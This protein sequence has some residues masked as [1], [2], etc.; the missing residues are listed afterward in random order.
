M[1]AFLRQLGLNRGMTMLSA[2]LFATAAAASS[3]SAV[4]WTVNDYPGTELCAA[5][6]YVKGKTAWELRMSP[7]GAV[8]IVLP[9]KNPKGFGPDDRFAVAFFKGADQRDRIARYFAEGFVGENSVGYLLMT[10]TTAQADKSNTD[11]FL[12]DFSQT[13]R[14]TISFEGEQFL[15]ITI[16]RSRQAVVGQMSACLSAVAEGRDF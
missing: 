2:I 3:D 16:P 8:S 4:G 10:Y 5:R 6:R 13:G 1:I 9:A 11:R 14:I 7:D 12:R 15:S